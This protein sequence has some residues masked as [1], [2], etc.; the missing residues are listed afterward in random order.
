MCWTDSSIAL[1]WIQRPYAPWKPFV[2]NRVSEIQSVWEPSLWRHCPGES[3][4]GD[5]VTRGMK[6][7]KLIVSDLWWE[8]PSWLRESSESWPIAP[9]SD[10]PKAKAEEEAEEEAKKTAQVHAVVT[11]DPVIDHS[12]YST[13]LKL[14]RV[15]AYVLCF[16]IS[17]EGLKSDKN[18]APE[19]ELSAEEIINSEYFWYQRIQ[20]EAYPEEFEKLR[21]GEPIS[22]T[23]RILKLDPFFDEGYR[24]LRVGGRLQNLKFPEETKHQVILPHC[25]PVV[26][27]I[28]QATHARS[29][30][31]G[32]ETTLEILRE[33]IWPIQGRRDIKRV[34]RKCLVCQR[35]VTTPCTQ[36]MAP[37]PQES[38]VHP[39]IFSHWSR[40]CWPTLRQNQK[41]VY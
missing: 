1:Y 22:K 23:S 31:A 40:L 35:Q 14:I 8:G 26:E 4:P 21:N 15:T 24:V 18:G 17:I 27:K 3:N 7:R 33:K 34:L 38:S 25:H 19:R 36:K 20:T 5:S 37:L 29:M 39:P 28:V 9:P 6:I 30:H 11:Q 13:W 2:A 16:L 41:G 10:I 12:K 32:P